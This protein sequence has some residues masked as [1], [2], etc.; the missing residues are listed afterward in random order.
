MGDAIKSFDVLLYVKDSFKAS[1]KSTS[2]LIVATMNSPNKHLLFSPGHASGYLS[3][4]PLF[5]L[6]HHFLVWYVLR[7]I[8][9]S[10]YAFSELSAPLWWQRHRGCLFADVYK[11]VIQRLGV[12]ISLPK[13]LISDI[14]GLEGRV[15]VYK[16]YGENLYYYDGN[17]F[18]PLLK[19]FLPRVAYLFW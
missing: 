5:A 10:W 2:D 17:S 14:S 3:S 11:D 6:V 16:L 18:Y 8:D 19:H 4:W 15:D 1:Q 7:R 12:K 9:L 13:S